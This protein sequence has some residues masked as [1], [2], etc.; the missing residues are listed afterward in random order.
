MLHN[1]NLRHSIHGNWFLY[2]FAYYENKKRI[3]GPSCPFIR[4]SIHPSVRPSV[5]QFVHI[6]VFFNHPTDLNQKIS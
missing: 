5:R 2:V 6:L 3:M 4:P 1:K